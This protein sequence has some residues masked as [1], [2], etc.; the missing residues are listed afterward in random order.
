MVVWLVAVAVQLSSLSADVADGVAH[1][2]T[3]RGG[4]DDLM[5]LVGSI[6]AADG[7]D[8]VVDAGAELDAAVDDFDAA[9]GTANGAV[10]APIR[11][12]PVL[13]RQLRAATTLLD[14]AVQVGSDT[15]DGDR[16]S[17]RTSPDAPPR[18]PRTACWRS[19][20]ARRCST[21]CRA[22][23]RIPTWAATPR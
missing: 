11:V 18:H 13:G 20:P 17:S 4:T 16:R 15:A 8:E 6:G 22:P 14:S 23:S 12:L 21:S 19:A 5:S 7:D 10:L 3:A 9:L 2:D 1:V